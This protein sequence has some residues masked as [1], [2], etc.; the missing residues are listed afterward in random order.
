MEIVTQAVDQYTFVD[1]EI[2]I[3]RKI[4]NKLFKESTKTGY[5]NMFTKDEKELILH[6]EDNIK[7]QDGN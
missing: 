2:P 4:L 6:I 5:K 7:Q 1:E 3:W